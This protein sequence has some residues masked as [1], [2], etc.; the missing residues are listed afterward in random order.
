MVENGEDLFPVDYP[1]KAFKVPPDNPDVFALLD[2]HLFCVDNLCTSEIRSK[3]H[4]ERPLGSPPVR[5]EGQALKNAYHWWIYPNH[6]EDIYSK[7]LAR[8]NVVGDLVIRTGENTS[9]VIIR[10]GKLTLTRQA[11]ADVANVSDDRLL[12]C[13]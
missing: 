4:A 8:A 9:L 1:D 12:I 7:A 11:S 10:H 13:L 2:S 3:I 6:A 5:Y